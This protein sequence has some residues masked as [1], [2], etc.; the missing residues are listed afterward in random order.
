MLW[1]QSDWCRALQLVLN[2]VIQALFPTICRAALRMQAL[3]LSCLQ[4]LPGLK[5]HTVVL[6][7]MAKLQLGQRVQDAL[8][9]KPYAQHIPLDMS[10]QQLVLYMRQY[11]ES[12]G[13]LYKAGYL[14]R[15]LSYSNLLISED[16][17]RAIISDWETMG[18]VEVSNARLAIELSH[19]ARSMMYHKLKC[20]S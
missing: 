6:A 7:G 2:T 16:R 19:A 12:V 14:H 13:C 5:D 11:V 10:F 1:A 8:I 3:N 15:D 18:R 4:T 9:I 20:T 17:K